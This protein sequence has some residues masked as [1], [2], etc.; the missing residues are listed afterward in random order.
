MLQLAFVARLVLFPLCSEWVLFPVS[1]IDGCLFIMV[2]V[3]VAVEVLHP[4]S[5][6]GTG[7]MLR[8]D[9]TA[10]RRLFKSVFQPCCWHLVFV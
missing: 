8:R 5:V 9:V 3:D 10:C 4:V 7:V 6:E 2:S 1:V